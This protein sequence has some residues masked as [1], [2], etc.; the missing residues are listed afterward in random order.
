MRNQPIYF[1]NNATTRLD[2]RVSAAVREAEDQGLANPASQHAAGRKALNLLVQAKESIQQSLGAP[3]SGSSEAQIIITSGG[4]EANNLVLHA[5]THQTPGLVI[6][7]SMEHPS[8]SLAAEISTLCLN[9][10]RRLSALSSGK[11]DLDQLSDWLKNVYSGRDP[12]KQVA[13]VSLMLANNETGVVNDLP[14]IVR[15]CQRNAVP[16]HCDIVQAVGKI[17]FDMQE[18]GLAAITVSAHKVHGP[19]GIGALIVN[20]TIQPRPLIVGGGQQLGW[21]AGTEPVAL[22]VGL[23][24]TLE[25]AAAE[26]E[27]GSYF[28]VAQLRDSF[29][30]QVLGGLS[31]ANIN[32]QLDARLPQTSSIAFEG[33]DRQALQMALDLEGLACSA[34]AA[35]SSGSARPSATLLAM[36]LSE[37]QIAGTIRF[38]IS[39]MTTAEEV[40]QASQ[41]VIRVAQKLLAARK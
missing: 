23:A 11:Y 28:R 16:V 5:L 38:S 2:S 31:F 25:I 18:C 9:P 33:L 21:R 3:T 26:R 22:A 17:A 14:E 6:V 36:G 35:C 19:P 34:G 8:L 13:L 7:G 10:V 15:L 27:S 24:K 41:I 37:R 40:D 4:T 29:E 32:G 39:R 12:N 1:D 30:K 20:H